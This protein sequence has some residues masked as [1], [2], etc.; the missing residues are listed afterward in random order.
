MRLLEEYLREKMKEIV[1]DGDF[2]SEEPQLSD[3]QV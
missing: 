1:F 2:D 3:D